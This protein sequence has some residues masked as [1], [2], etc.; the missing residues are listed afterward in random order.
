MT[1]ISFDTPCYF[2]TSVALHRLPIFQTDKLKEIMC[3]ALNDARRS[4]GILY[5]AYVIMQEHFHILTDGKRLP[6]DSLRFLNGVS[7]RKI[8]DYLKENGF[9]A[10]LAKLKQAKKK[11]GWQ[12]SVW[13]HHSDKFLLTSESKFM[14]KVYYI[15]NNPVVE[16]LVERPEDY[17]HS[18][19]RIWQGKPLESEP[20]EMDIGDIDWQR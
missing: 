12:Y 9:D 20:L 11:D 5:F 15:H 19:A 4:S 1:R 10:S 17:L 2:F 13:E 7:A 16:G 6:S 8:I 18:S 14:E 3:G